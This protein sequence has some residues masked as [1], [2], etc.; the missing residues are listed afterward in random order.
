MA[1]SN[2]G[3]LMDGYPM[4]LPLFTSHITTVELKSLYPKIEV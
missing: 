1:L 4:I 2:Y 3:D